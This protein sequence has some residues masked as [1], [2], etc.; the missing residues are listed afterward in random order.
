MSRSE[1]AQALEVTTAAVIKWETGD[2][3][4]EYA[5]LL[6]MAKLL[7]CSTDWLL[8]NSNDPERRLNADYVSVMMEMQFEGVTPE[9]LRRAV[10]ILKATEKL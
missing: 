5:T 9:D 7:D 4:P 10:R 3:E 2:R 1:L 6:R 8:G